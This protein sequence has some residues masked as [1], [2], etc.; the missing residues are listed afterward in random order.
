MSRFISEST[1]KPTFFSTTF[2]DSILNVIWFFFLIPA[3][4]RHPLSLN[5]NKFFLNAFSPVVFFILWLLTLTDSFINAF[6][7]VTFLIPGLLT[8]SDSFLTVFSTLAFHIHCPLPSTDSFLTAFSSATFLISFSTFLTN[9][10]SMFPYLIL[11][12]FSLSTLCVSW[13]LSIPT[14]AK[15]LSCS[16][17]NC[18]LLS[19]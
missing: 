12:I 19:S 9:S 3:H 11:L 17:V 15:K 5:L 10:C 2:L 8:S 7:S 1:L 4:L 16:G 18:N 14:Q 6:S 13:Y